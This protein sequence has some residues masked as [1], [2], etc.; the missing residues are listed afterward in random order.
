MKQAKAWLGLLIA[1]I[2]TAALLGCDGR[3]P[4]PWEPTAPQKTPSGV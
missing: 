1:L 2:A 3:L 4:R